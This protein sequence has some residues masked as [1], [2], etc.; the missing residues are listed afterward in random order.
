MRCSQVGAEPDLPRHNG[1]GH[2]RGASLGLG[3]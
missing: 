3:R 1:A 2:G